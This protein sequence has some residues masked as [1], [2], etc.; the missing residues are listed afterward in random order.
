MV[1]LFGTCSKVARLVLRRSLRANFALAVE[2]GAISA[3]RL[4]SLTQG[5][6]RIRI[7]ITGLVDGLGPGSG[8]SIVKVGGAEGMDSY[9]PD[10]NGR[11]VNVCQRTAIA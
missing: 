4:E 9:E 11:I 5:R 7:P 3:R 8:H 6:A 2:K 1:K 10:Q